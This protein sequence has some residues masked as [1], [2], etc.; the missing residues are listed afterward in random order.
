MER[1]KGENK[2][3][4][5][6]NGR[7]K[8]KRKGKNGGVEKEE[9]RTQGN[10]DDEQVA[11]HG[12]RKEQEGR[13]TERGREREGGELTLNLQS[14]QDTVNKPQPLRDTFL[15]F[16]LRCSRKS[17]SHFYCP[18]QDLFVIPLADHFGG[19]R[20]RRGERRERKRTP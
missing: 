3:D 20:G 7:Q 9:E 10:T 1:Q 13:N 17:K 11:K 19:R 12:R 16:L 15:P 18:A 4:G 2:K 8:K 6:G 5:R 14:D